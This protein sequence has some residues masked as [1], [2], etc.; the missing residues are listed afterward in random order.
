M[1]Q[2]TVQEWP[3]ERVRKAR[4][5]AVRLGWVSG[6]W[7]SG[8]GLMM[9]HTAVLRGACTAAVY[10]VSKSD[11]LVSTDESTDER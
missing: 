2:Q 4:I 11:P 1:K 9:R 8:L 10:R 5:Q 6:F 3:Y 7:R